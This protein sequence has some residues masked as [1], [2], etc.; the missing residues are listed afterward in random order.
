M[1]APEL[2]KLS[3]A[4]RHK[5]VS[6]P[7]DG[8]GLKTLLEAGMIWLKT[9]QQ[10]VNSLNVFPVPDGDTGTNMVLTMQAAFEEV[11]TAGSSNVGQLAHSIARGA[12]MGARGN[13][14]VILS[15]IWRGFA[16]AL[17]DHPTMDVKLLADALEEARATAYKGVVRPVEGTILTVIKDIAAQAAVS[18]QRTSSF[19]EVLWDIVEAA[20]ASVERTPDLL[21][22]LKQAG[23]VDSGG[24]GLM[25]LFE[26]MWRFINGESLDKAVT[27]V[28][29][30]SEMDLE[31][32][33]ETVEEGQDYEVV[34]DFTPQASFNLEE[35][36]DELSKIGTSIQVGEGDGM[37]RMHI[38][39][40]LESRYQPIDHTMNLGTVQKVMMENLVAQ[41]DERKN[42]KNPKIKLTPVQP[43]EI[44]VVA[45]SPGPGLSRIF[46][47]LGVAALVHGGQT[48]NP[49][50]KELL[51]SFE[52]LPTDNIIILPNNKNIIMA[53]KEAASMTVKNVAVIPTIS[54]PQ[55]LSAMFR[56]IPDSDFDEIVE[57]MNEAVT[58]VETGEITTATR[59]VEIDGVQVENGQVIALHNGKL[60]TSTHSIEEACESLLVAA[61]TS[62]YERITLFYGEDI[63]LNRVNELAD[64]IRSIYPS[65]EIEVHEG[66]QPHYQLIISIE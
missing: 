30:L 27:E 63:Q 28:L 53:A 64:K 35:Y 39:V 13:S 36:Y 66:G 61:D 44:A 8:Q 65:H 41:M 52:N 49:S 19:T 37:Y 15:Q 45:V 1:S 20:N 29:P 25:F 58:E 4:E 33:M 10:T 6:V 12:L 11:S 18:V 32:A 34:I 16:R 17:N 50:I 46:A 59:T 47:S 54:V 38:H 57:A 42:N 60:V 26:G 5:L 14:G 2:A 55:G 51:A 24:K 56:L 22:I 3:T 48:M 31:N 21:P 7:I 62:D 40:P 9:N 23:V 43:D